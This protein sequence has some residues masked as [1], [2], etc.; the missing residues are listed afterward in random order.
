MKLK[1]GTIHKI[2]KKKGEKKKLTTQPHK[3]GFATRAQ[4]QNKGF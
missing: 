3:N 2:K 1:N 4:S